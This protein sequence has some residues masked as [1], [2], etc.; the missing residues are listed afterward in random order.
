[1]TVPEPWLC[2]AKFEAI[3]KVWVAISVCVDVP[4]QQHPKPSTPSY[5]IKRKSTF[6]CP[7]P[8][9]ALSVKIS[10]TASSV[11]QLIKMHVIEQSHKMVLKC[12]LRLAGLPLDHSS[13]PYTWC[14][15]WPHGASCF[16]GGG[17]VWK[18][19]AR[20]SSL[21]IALFVCWLVVEFLT[22][23]SHIW[24]Y[25]QIISQIISVFFCH[26]AV[27]TARRMFSVKPFRLDVLHALPTFSVVLGKNCT[28]ERTV[29]FRHLANLF[30]GY[31][32]H[33]R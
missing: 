7:G 25:V 29:N 16:S 3:S 27:K 21:T 4:K 5:A 32:L 31:P 28:G 8:Y 15:R 12:C 10:T 22:F 30:S 33:S 18:H 13:W 20:Q 26:T 1:M 6:Q 2:W 17:V 11:N 24:L 14:W 19:R 9:M 23:E